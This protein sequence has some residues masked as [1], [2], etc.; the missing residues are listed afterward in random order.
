M[1]VIFVKFKRLFVY[2]KMSVMQVS[3]WFLDS[4]VMY[5]A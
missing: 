3:S 2:G 4:G 5:E 1:K